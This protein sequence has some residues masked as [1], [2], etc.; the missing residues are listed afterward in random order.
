MDSYLYPTNDGWLEPMLND[1]KH[2]GLPRMAF[3]FFGFR[4]TTLPQDTVRP[5]WMYVYYTKRSTEDEALRGVVQFRVRVI[6]HSF[7]PIIDAG[8]HNRDYE[9]QA[10]DKEK[11][12]F[13][14][15]LVE[16]VTNSAGEALRLA[17]FV[18][19]DGVKLSSAI[20]NSIAP[21]KRIVPMVTVQTT[22]YNP[23]D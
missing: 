19:R 12:Y 1:W 7:E 9:L 16:E 5:F 18:H 17:D 10:G 3:P 2:S 11:V 4:V 14:I 15:D 23:Q 20:Y 21:I 6:R 13:L 22:S 8:A